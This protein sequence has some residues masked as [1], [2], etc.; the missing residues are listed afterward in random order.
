M[1]VN[2]EQ[3]WREISN[4]LDD[5]LEPGLRAAL[6]EHFR[7]CKHCTSVLEGTRNV[8]RLYGDPQMFELPLGFSQRLQRRIDQSLLRPRGTAWGWVVALA[9]SLL[10]V[11]GVELG[12]LSAFTTPALRSELADPATSHIAEDMQV[13]VTTDGKTFH[14]GAGCPYMHGKNKERVISV[15]EAVR[16][17]YTPC[18]RCMTKYLSAKS[19][20]PYFPADL[21]AEVASLRPLR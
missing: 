3:V 21:A 4:Y 5:D 13:V 9:A 16:E 2:C 14:G 10:L 17:G 6:E 15:R 20:S 19:I 11:G 18:T 12:H 8:I 1:G 7:G